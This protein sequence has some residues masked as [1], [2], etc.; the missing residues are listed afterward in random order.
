MLQL[1]SGYPWS[2]IKHGL[3]H[4][5]P[6]LQENITAEVVVIGGGISGALTAYELTN[7]GIETVV[8]DSRSIGL[9]STCASTSLIQYEIDI[10]LTELAERIG[11]QKAEQAYSLCYESLSAL[12][13]ICRRVNAYFEP[14]ESLFLASLKKHMPLLEKEYVARKAL[15]FDVDLWSPDK[16]SQTMGFSA[17]AA[18]YSAVAAQTDAYALTHALHQY[19]IKK[20]ARVFERTHIADVKRTPRQVVLSSQ[21][22]WQIKARYLV[23]A[24]GYEAMQHISEPLVKLHSTYAVVS[25]PIEQEV[26]WHRNCLIWET[27]DPY[28][29]MRTTPDKRVLIGGRDDPYYNPSRRDRLI[30]R[31]TRQLTNDFNKKFPDITFK[32][33]MEWAGTFAT[34]EDGLPF[35]GTYPGLSHTFFTLGFGGN[36]VTF[37]Q[38]AAEIIRDLI[39]GKKNEAAR[40]FAFG[41]GC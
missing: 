22:G 24:T 35:I 33:D 9:G 19:N 4:T 36:G 2:L 29:Y 39:T 23:V 7:A 37:S 18:L 21:D 16:L 1:Q 41:R 14:R 11:L 34:T 6:S 10:P 31:K 17:P 27:R 25:E 12:E 40:L 30:H 3:P 26:L 15:G 8:V 20:E 32:P 5:Y 28:L 13:K 38:I